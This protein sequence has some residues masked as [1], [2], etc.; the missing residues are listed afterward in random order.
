MYPDRLAVRYGAAVLLE[1]QLPL[2]R[3]S[4]KTGGIKC[5]ARPEQAR[6][7]DLH[8]SESRFDLGKIDSTSPSTSDAQS[9]RCDGRRVCPAK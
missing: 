5:K 9:G 4:P 1:E 8:I 2:S 7:K 3:G 6:H